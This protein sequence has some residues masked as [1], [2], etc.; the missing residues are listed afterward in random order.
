VARPFVFRARIA[1][2]NN[3]T[4]GEKVERRKALKES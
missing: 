4:H 1:K 3:E 2:T